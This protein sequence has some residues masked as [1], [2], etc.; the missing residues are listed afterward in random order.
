MDDSE[1][2]RLYNQYADAH[3][4]VIDWLTRLKQIEA[5][6]K[7]L[8]QQLTHTAKKHAAACATKEAWR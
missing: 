7:A 3:N 5:E 8:I 6:G 2:D 1:L 4:A